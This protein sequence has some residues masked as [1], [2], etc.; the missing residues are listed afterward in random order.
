MSYKGNQIGISK[1]E[2]ILTQKTDLKSWKYRDFLP[3]PEPFVTK[4]IEDDHKNLQ[5]QKWYE[6]YAKSTG[7]AI[8]RRADD[9]VRIAKFIAS[10]RGILWES[11]M[12]G[13]ETIQKELT[14][15]SLQNY[16]SIQ[17]D[18]Q[19]SPTFWGGVKD[20]LVSAGQAILTNIGLTAATLVQTALSGTGYRGDTY[21][22]RAYLRKGTGSSVL[23]TLLASA[24]I[25]DGDYLVGAT[26]VQKGQ[27]IPISGDSVPSERKFIPTTDPSTEQHVNKVNRM[28]PVPNKKEYGIDTALTGAG[29]QGA[30]QS[31]SFSNP[32]GIPKSL[33][34]DNRADSRVR[35]RDL[36]D[37]KKGNRYGEVKS[38]RNYKT[39]PSGAAT[40]VES[41]ENRYLKDVDKKVQPWNYTFDYETP[42]GGGGKVSR[43]TSS[44]IIQEYVADGE[45]LNY[46]SGSTST[47][48]TGNVKVVDGESIVST[49]ATGSTYVIRRGQYKGYASKDQVQS[50]FYHVDTQKTKGAGGIVTE[51]ISD[52]NSKH[53]EESLGLTPFCISTF[54][55]EKRTYINFPINLE[56][57]DDT[58]NGNW[59]AV[60]YVGRGEN[61]YGY[62]GFTRSINFAFKVVALHPR[63][64]L[65]LYRRLNKVAGATAPSYDETGLFMRGT[66]SCITIGDLL[67]EQFGFISNVKITWQKDYLWVPGV[68]KDDNDATG[69]QR[70]PIM[71]PNILDV[72]IS[73]TPIER[74]IVT[75]NYRSFFVFKPSVEASIEVGPLE[76]HFEVTKPEESKPVDRGYDRDELRKRAE[77]EM[78]GSAQ[79][80]TGTVMG[81]HNT[82]KGGGGGTGNA[83]ELS[84]EERAGGRV[85]G[86][87]A[88]KV[89]K[90]EFDFKKSGTSTS[91][92]FYTP[93]FG[94]GQ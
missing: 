92:L 64:L 35:D 66:L 76:E 75:E 61:F 37:I 2:G 10:G 58:Y 17:E 70:N 22:S 73:Y 85:I 42:V 8:E 41:E 18:I 51:G 69:W 16:K 89:A 59:E 27:N 90:Q 38:T 6:R 43:S 1:I 93:G 13:L 78:T 23:L 21:A 68:N 34:F 74:K 56:S 33:T 14:S 40:R 9:A 63:D 50:Y 24:G 79:E 11:K 12:A 44:N 36:E 88:W 45:D 86:T 15:K 77:S 67:V 83:S 46:G 84:P 7:V 57:Y 39:D 49:A 72:S 5:D 3:G 28:D 26:Y 48:Y 32:L 31:L 80:H 47:T 60:Q 25:A 91:D 29:K 65:E 81:G 94:N 19:Q 55:P 4:D 54:T 71:L 20:L 53:L 52:E 30:T 62:T 82:V 87:T